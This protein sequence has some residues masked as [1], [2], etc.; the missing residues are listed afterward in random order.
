GPQEEETTAMSLE[1]GSWTVK[2]QVGNS[3]LCPN[4]AAEATC[5]QTVTVKSCAE[6][7][8]DTHCQSLVVTPPHGGNYPGDYRLDAVAVDDSLD[9]PFYTFVATR[10]AAPPIQVGPLDSGLAFVSLDA[11]VWSIQALTGDNLLCPPEQTGAQ[12]ITV[13][14]LSDKPNV[15]LQ[16]AATQSTTYP[17]LPAPLGNDGNR[18]TFTATAATDE[19]AAWEV[20]LGGLFAIEAVVLRN[21]LDCCRSRLR[22]IQIAILDFDGTQVWISELLNVE[23]ELGGQ[24]LDAPLALTL[25]IL[26]LNGQ[27][28]DGRFVR[29]TRLPDPDLSG[30]LGAGGPDEMNILTLAEVEVFAAPSALAASVTRKLALPTFHGDETVQVSLDVLSTAAPV[31]V[32]VRE[33]VPPLALV[34]EITL[35]GVYDPAGSITWSLPAAA[36]TT[37]SYTIAA[38]TSC[39]GQL[40]FGTS[41]FTV[42]GK[43]AG[44]VGESILRRAIAPTP[45]DAW[46][47]ADIG[48]AASLAEAVADHSL[49]LSATAAGVKGSADAL[50]FI[51]TAQAGDFELTAKLD[52]VDDPAGASQTGLM[53]R[54]S[55]DPSAAHAFVFLSPAGAAAGKAGT[56]KGLFRRETS[57]TRA[58]A[59]ITI[60]QKDVDALPIWLKLKRSGT[61]IGFERSSDGASY[62][63]IAS[64]E[65]GT[66]T[67]QVNLGPTPLAGLAAA[68]ASDQPVLVTFSD[69]S[70]PSFKTSGP[71]LRRG[72]SDANA[73]IELTDAVSLLNYLFLGGESPACLDAA[74]FD[75]N[76]S[77]DISDAIASLNYQFLG[78]TAPAA[79]GPTNCGPDPTA[80][81]PDL[82]CAKGC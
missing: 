56:L 4:P 13:A 7:P 29:V 66:G 58:V 70:G 28:V 81:Q 71:T 20:D 31:V 50:S 15:A 74:D 80:E 10:G 5:E 82:G 36:S 9:A 52:C 38:A 1:S 17:N 6:N 76:G 40:E 42:D 14:Q 54:D 60:A 64:R 26:A 8:P 61:K 21:R 39:V 65:I 22:D 55:T 43:T 30:T 19:Q 46:Q 12:E 18:A 16:G 11:G 32:A 78:G 68:S 62:V 51:A 23:N 37:V 3:P 53:L 45:L 33:A 34:S 44:V 57:P 25:S 2:A 27:S 59:P 69:V 48:G 73:A 35:G 41:S 24:T 75:D 79:P 77:A 67:S 49:L 47:S 72:D 63:E